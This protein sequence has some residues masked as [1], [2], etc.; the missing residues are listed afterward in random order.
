LYIVDEQARTRV[1]EHKIPMFLMDQIIEIKFFK[2]KKK[3]KNFAPPNYF[4]NAMT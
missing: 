4:E 3:H 2:I 1:L